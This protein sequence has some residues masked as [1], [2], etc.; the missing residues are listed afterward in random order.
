MNRQLQEQNHLALL[1]SDI[2]YLPNHVCPK[3]GAAAETDRV[4]Q[5]LTPY[6]DW[7]HTT[8]SSWIRNLGYVHFQCDCFSGSL[9]VA[10]LGDAIIPIEFD[11]GSLAKRL[12]MD[13]AWIN[14]DRMRQAVSFLARYTDPEFTSGSDKLAHI[15]YA[16]AAGAF[17][18]DEARIR[19]EQWLKRQHSIPP[20]NGLFN[21]SRVSQRQTSRKL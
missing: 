3:C 4:G 13:T 21:Q 14:A 1:A 15:L 12:G 20:I 17:S 18:P 2:Q 9:R 5:W 10:R 16:F 8:L 11:N 19:I 7:Y 6:Q